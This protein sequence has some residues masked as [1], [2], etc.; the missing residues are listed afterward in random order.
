MGKIIKLLIVYS[1]IGLSV[2]S[3][4]AAA[5]LIKERDFDCKE[6]LKILKR[7]GGKPNPG[8]VLQ[9]EQFALITKT[10]KLK[11]ERQVEVT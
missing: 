1:Y 3:V 9:L 5:Y 8:F 2:C 10:S 6:A 4:F 7:K 11:K